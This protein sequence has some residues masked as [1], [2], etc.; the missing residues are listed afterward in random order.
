MLN[1]RVSTSAVPVM[2][3]ARYPQEGSSTEVKHNAA[4]SRPD[5]L[6]RAAGSKSARIVE[7]KT[8]ARESTSILAEDE[9][10]ESIV[11]QKWMPYHHCVIVITSNYCA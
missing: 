6:G 1:D 2:C 3:I 7:L 4:S 10:I 9:K 11:F 8:F 5:R